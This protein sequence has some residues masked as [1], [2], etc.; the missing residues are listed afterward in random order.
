MSNPVNPLPPN[1]DG[2]QAIQSATQNIGQQ[3]APGFDARMQGQPNAAQMNQSTQ[4]QGPSPLDLS[5]TSGVRGTPTFD[6]LTNQARNAQD[7]LGQVAQQTKTVGKYMND[8]PNL[9]MT[10]PQTQL[11][12]RHL[13]DTNENINKAAN[14]VGAN[15]SALE[16][17]SS[18]NTIAR[19]LTWVGQGQDTLTSV[20]GKLQELSKSPESLN[21]ADMMLAQVKMNQAQNEIQFSTMLLSKVIDSFKQILQTQL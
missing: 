19:F 7:N 12:K 2:E 14:A 16:P 4:A 8:N 15:P 21:P 13:Q 11:L 1:V 5:N 20:Q 9:K 3:A 17:G 6:S 10:R 18:S